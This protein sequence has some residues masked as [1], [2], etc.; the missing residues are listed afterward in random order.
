MPDIA[1]LLHR[2]QRLIQGLFWLTLAIVVTLSLLPRP[3]EIGDFENSDKVGHLLAYL[4]LGAL[5]GLGWRLT[6]TRPLVRAFVALVLLGALIE[7]AQGLLPVART[8]SAL[9]L[10]ADALGAG[11]ALAANAWFWER[12]GAA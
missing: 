1:H 7:L 10:L 9:D 5:L 11:L 4:D 2:H 3:I 6:R 12:Q 8:C